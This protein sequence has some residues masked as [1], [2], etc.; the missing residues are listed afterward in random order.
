MKIS[1]IQT[2]MM[3]VRLI[4]RV[5]EM[6]AIREVKTK[7]GTQTRVCEATISDESGTMKLTLW[8][9]QIDKIKPGDSVEIVNGIAREWQGVKQL[10][11]SEKRGE[12]K[13][14]P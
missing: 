2:G 7:F 1:E 5:E 12:L 4:A 14:N 9:E 13:V 8:A 11:V 3:G 10:S 6:G